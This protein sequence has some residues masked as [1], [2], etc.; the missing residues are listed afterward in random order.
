MPLVES[1]ELLLNLVRRLDSLAPAP[2]GNHPA[3]PSQE[4]MAEENH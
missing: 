1:S 2:A 4:G 3:P